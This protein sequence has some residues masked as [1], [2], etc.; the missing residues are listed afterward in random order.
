MT[1][2]ARPQLLTVGHGT[3]PAEEF[4]AL[5][6]GAGV[7]LLVDVRSFPGSR[8]NPQFKREAMEQWVPDGGT[9]YRWERRLG[10]RRRAPKDSPVLDT[11]WRVEAF[12]SY[13]AYTRTA[14]W[15]AGFDAL[16]SD[17]GDRRVAICC[18]EAVW[19]RCHRR[20][21]ADVVSLTQPV[22]VLDL[23]HDGRLTPHP[24]AEGARVGDD[25]RVVWDGGAE[26]LPTD[27]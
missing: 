20:L 1:A 13:A 22:D 23:A 16:M 5:L 9:A 11:W 25:G 27:E 2:A 26:P 24:V 12:R 17:V 19:W 4:S 3:L 8:A 7:E 15:A 14:D 18:S 10:G 21:I 6:R